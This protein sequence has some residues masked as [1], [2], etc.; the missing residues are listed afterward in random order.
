[1]TIQIPRSRHRRLLGIGSLG[2]EHRRTVAERHGSAG[3]DADDDDW[4]VDA[5]RHAD[6]HLPLAALQSERLALR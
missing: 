5:E 6:L 3:P 4:H 1:M 2:D